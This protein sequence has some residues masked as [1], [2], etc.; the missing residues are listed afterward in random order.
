MVISLQ[1]PSTPSGHQSGKTLHQGPHDSGY[2]KR[3][4]T[5]FKRAKIPVTIMSDDS[6]ILDNFQGMKRSAW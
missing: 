5:G 2:G 4:T 1:I 3:V 6:P